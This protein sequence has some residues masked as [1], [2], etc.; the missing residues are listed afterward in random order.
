M[1]IISPKVINSTYKKWND[2]SGNIFEQKRKNYIE[3][4]KTE[5][6]KLNKT[7]KKK[8]KPYKKAKKIKETKRKQRK[9]ERMKQINEATKG[10]P[11]FLRVPV[12]QSTS[13]FTGGQKNKTI[14]KRNIKRHSKHSNQLNQSKKQSRHKLVI[15]K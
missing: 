12:R 2:L 5:R 13:L 4:L 8:R 3:K 6:K 14:K 9:K 7:K 10:L 15:E 11:L 1:E